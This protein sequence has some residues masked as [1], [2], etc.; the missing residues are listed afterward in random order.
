MTGTP[1]LHLH[2]NLRSPSTRRIIIN[3][4][5][6]G[7]RTQ[8]LTEFFRAPLKPAGAENDMIWLRKGRRAFWHCVPLKIHTRHKGPGS[9]W[10]GGTSLMFFSTYLYRRQCCQAALHHFLP[11]LPSSGSSGSAG[12]VWTWCAVSVSARCRWGGFPAELASSVVAPHP[13]D[14]AE[15]SRTAHLGAPGVSAWSVALSCPPVRSLAPPV[16]GASGN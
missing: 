10:G 2:S 16:C 11:R 1:I 13:G 14:A 9:D 5:L 7:I 15:G 4:S 6:G 12:A 3:Y 8:S